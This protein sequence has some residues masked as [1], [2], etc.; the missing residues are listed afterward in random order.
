MIATLKANIKPLLI[1]CLSWGL[2]FIIYWPLLFYINDAGDLTAGWRIVWADWALHLSQVHAFAY[3]PFFY[4]LSNNPI[5]AGHDIA[6]PFATNLVSGLLVK[7]G[8]SVVLAFVVPS[9]IYSLC[10][11]IALYTFGKIMTQSGAAAI[12]GI[13]LFLLSGGFEFYYYFGDLAKD[14]SLEKMLYPPE[15]Y[16]FLEDKGF[17]WKSVILSSLIPQRALLMGMP[18][19][20]F[21][22]SYLLYHYKS[23]FV[24][25]RDEYLFL[26]GL[27]TGPLAIVHSHS[28]L[29]LFFICAFLFFTDL[30]NYRRWIFY[31]VGVAL[32]AVPWLHY[33]VGSDTSGFLEFYPGWYS[34]K[35][36]RDEFFLLFWLRN[37]GLFFPMAIIALG[38]VFVRG[39]RWLNFGSFLY[40]KERLLYIAFAILFVL[41]N[42]FKFQPNLWDNTKLLLWSHLGL[43]FLVAHFLVLLFRKGHAAKFATVI[44]VWFTC[45]SGLVDLVKSLHVH[46]ESYVMLPRAQL[47]L[48][49]KLRELSQHD[50]IIMSPNHHLHF[51]STV[52]G[53]GILMGYRGWLWTY[54]FD[55]GERDR[56][57]SR[58]YQGDS[59]TKSLLVKHSIDYVV[60]D[61]LALK[62]YSADKAYFDEHYEK[63]IDE[64]G[65]NVYRVPKI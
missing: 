15:H 37:W 51:T 42:L 59:E 5:F 54:G 60:I 47:E 38:L 26:A 16:T 50:D 64:H 25:A 31:G 14:F 23:G 21:S 22:L 53:R 28:L 24:K 3:Q 58:I 45:M 6:Y 13:F 27:L 18:W 9:L 39:S 19:M 11:L 36:E 10:L 4:V 41:A 52:T 32:T 43:S 63:V 29:A 17:Y 12:L 57:M 33:L 55:S 34:N 35:S 20:L 7:S 44:L 61:Q 40:G 46:R 1:L 8:V 49:E 48:G 2:Y 65:V 56:D 30:K 62:D